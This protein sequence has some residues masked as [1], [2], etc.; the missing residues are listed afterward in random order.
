MPSFV[1]DVLMRRR[2]D[3]AA[4]AEGFVFATSKGTPLDPHN[5][6]TKLRKARGE[7][8]EWVTPHV[9][10]KTV[11]TLVER[12]AGVRDSSL[13]L[14]HADTGVTGRHYVERLHDAPDVS[15]ILDLLAPSVRDD[16][17]GGHRRIRGSL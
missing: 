7:G 4:S 6:R 3:A 10:R 15:N 12:E 14:G 9:L 5:V 11:A 13:L 16:S 17:A 8:F 1:V 2:V